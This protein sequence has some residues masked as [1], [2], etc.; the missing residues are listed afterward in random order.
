ML[1]VWQKLE[2]VILFCYQGND[3]EIE[4]PSSLVKIGVRLRCECFGRES[5]FALHRT[6]EGGETGPLP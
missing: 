4:F 3:L 6:Y 5:V 1:V 2:S